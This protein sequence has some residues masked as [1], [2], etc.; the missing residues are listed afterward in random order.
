MSV[1]TR[2]KA[3]KI[4]WHE[5][6]NQ[7]LKIGAL[8]DTTRCSARPKIAIGVSGGADSMALAY[9]LHHF[10][11]PQQ[12]GT[13]AYEVHTYI[14]DHSARAGS[15][16]EALLVRQNLHNLGINSELLTI[17]WPHGLDPSSTSGFEEKARLARY[18]LI[19]RSAL[20]Q[21][22]TSVFTGHHLDDN[23]E[24]LIFRLIRNRKTPLYSLGGI[25]PK[26][27]VP[28]EHVFGLHGYSETTESGSLS[29]L[30]SQ[31]KININEQSYE[32]VALY[33][34]LLLFP[35]SRLLATCSTYNIP[36]VD[37]KTNHDPKYATR[38][39]IRYVRKYNLPKAL[40]SHRLLDL[41]GRASEF[42]DR[43]EDSAKKLFQDISRFRLYSE[44]GAVE[45][46]VNVPQGVAD[47]ISWQY[48]M[49]RII[50]LVAP[51]NPVAFPTF[52]PAKKLS[53]ILQTTRVDQ[54][55]T[56]RIVLA[57]TMIHVARPTSGK[58]YLRLVIHRQPLGRDEIK[59][60]HM[61]FRRDVQASE[62]SY[63]GLYCS[64][65]LLWDGRFWIRVVSPDKNIIAKLHVRTYLLD[66]AQRLR[67]LQKK[68][69][70]Y[71]SFRT[72]LSDLTPL[73]NTFLDTGRKHTP[74]ILIQQTLPVIVHNDQIVAFPT[75]D[76]M[77]DATSV[78][79]LRWEVKYR[80]ANRALDFFAAYL[81]NDSIAKAPVSAIR[82]IP[83]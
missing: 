6:G 54:A 7:L 61:P 36:Y 41:Q 47:D 5:L 21:G 37:D 50:E 29:F 25:Q 16:D 75:V 20:D 33:R 83:V 10:G 40:Q 19:A 8:P 27:L 3:D 64:R 15:R 73:E 59:E 18:D 9:L 76:F 66:D 58:S 67:R 43:I 38:N 44:T 55:S 1:L 57:N 34:P 82:T 49:A 32:G 13:R 62:T 65:W 11:H 72:W 77:V 52:V 70:V 17:K 12:R 69:E 42:I 51:Q 79:G 48:L 68:Q 78:P 22:C 30:S 28:C 39:A 14:V 24:T 74:S 63:H 71:H 56:S 2:F 35:K 46:K 81:Q 45:M 53:Q 60:K 80:R 31:K 23:V 4:C 26:S